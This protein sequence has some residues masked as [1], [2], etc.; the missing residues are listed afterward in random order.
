MIADAPG[1]GKALQASEAA[2][3]PVL[4]CCPAYLIMQWEKFLISQYPDDFVCAAFGLRK[5]RELILQVDA[6]WY[7]V[8]HAMLR[9]YQMPKVNTVIF[10][11][12]HHLRGCNAVQSLQALNY[13]LEVENVFLLTGSPIVREADD[14]YMQL[15]MLDPLVFSTRKKFIDMYCN[16]YY[17]PWGTRAKGSKFPS[18]MKQMLSRYVLERTYDDVGMQLPKLT[19]E[20][21]TVDMDMTI[22]DKVKLTYRDLEDVP[23]TAAMAMIIELRRLT[24]SEE[25]IKALVDTV[26]DIGSPCIVFTWFKETAAFLSQRLKESKQLSNYLRNVSIITGDIPTETRED[27]AK[28]EN[29]TIV[30]TMAS[31][32]EG[33]DL[34]H[35]RHVIFFEEDYTPGMIYQCMCR[36]RRFS[37]EN[38]YDPV[39]VYYVH[40]R[41]T[42]DEIIHHCV[43]ERIS[44]IKE[45]FKMS[46]TG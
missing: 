34:S 26:M 44:D 40:V 39:V 45:I 25:K 4:V 24:V 9:G 3:K 12:S 19:E 17:T 15:K 8:N 14:L 46:I 10:D 23:L 11:E 42:I 33:V 38:N 35:F 22:Y 21:I 2:T 18:L 6:D 29:T 5:N 41:D 13:S 43:S 32:S 36:V 30:A 1:L 28:R 31:M 37:T 16:G 20:T 7:I 27:L